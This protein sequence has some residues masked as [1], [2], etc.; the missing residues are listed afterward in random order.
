MKIKREQLYEHLLE[1]QFM[2]VERTILDAVFDKEW[3]K[4]WWITP[5]QYES[6]EEYSLALI[7]K[8]LKCSSKKAKVAFDKF[9]E[10][11]GLPVQ[12]I[13]PTIYAR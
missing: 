8:T 2:L 12:R 13:K 1:R 3:W 11:H 7:K 6:F 9:I 4:K 10:L 5:E